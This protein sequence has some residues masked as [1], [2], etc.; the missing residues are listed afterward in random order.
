[1]GYT[2]LKYKLKLKHFIGQPMG[3]GFTNIIEI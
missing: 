1:M 2:L 3:A